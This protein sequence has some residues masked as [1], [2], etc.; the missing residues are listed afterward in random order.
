MVNATI[1]DCQRPFK[2]ANSESRLEKIMQNRRPSQTHGTNINYYS[3]TNLNVNSF[4]IHNTTL[5]NCNNNI[6]PVTRPSFFTSTSVNITTLLSETSMECYRLTVMLDF[7]VIVAIYL[8]GKCNY[9]LILETNKRYS[10]NLVR[11]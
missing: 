7:I 8:C 1:V 3:T 4:N 6:T 9:Q 2:F 5:E 10:T 11:T